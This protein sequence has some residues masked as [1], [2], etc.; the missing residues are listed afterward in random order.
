MFQLDVLQNQ[1][2]FLAFFGGI[3]MALA[4]VLAYVAF[5]RNEPAPPGGPAET[6]PRRRVPWVLIV[7][8]AIMIVYSV[9]YVVMQ[10][11]NP[12]TW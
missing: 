4:V 8:Y 10:A 11:M 6:P 3:A 5:W 1:W 2:V 12:Q 9:A 7:L